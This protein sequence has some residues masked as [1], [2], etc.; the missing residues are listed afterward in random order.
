M[1]DPPT[2]ISALPDPTMSPHVGLAVGAAGPISDRLAWQ[3]GQPT[4]SRF[5]LPVSADDSL[6]SFLCYPGTVSVSLSYTTITGQL[7]IDN[8]VL[9]SLCVVTRQWNAKT[10]SNHDRGSHRKFA[11][12]ELLHSTGLLKSWFAIQP[13]VRCRQ[14][15]NS[16]RTGPLSSCSAHLVHKVNFLAVARVSSFL[17][18]VFFGLFLEPAP[19]TALSIGSSTCPM[20]TCRTWLSSSTSPTAFR[21]L[22]TSQLC[23]H[24]WRTRQ[25]VLACGVL[26]AASLETFAVQRTTTGGS[27]PRLIQEDEVWLI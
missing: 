21:S 20:T 9:F 18:T 7:G 1:V 15:S 16:S 23:R 14:A 27:I 22:S 5:S 3:A 24:V 17:N 2:G 25:P 4:W 6:S 26:G 10:V 11:F 13:H 12:T 8:Q 19:P